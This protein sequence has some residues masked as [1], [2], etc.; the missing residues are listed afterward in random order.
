M[1]YLTI[2]NLSQSFGD[3]ILFD[4]LDMTIIPGQRVALIARNGTGKT[5]LLNV[6]MGSMLYPEWTVELNHNIRTRI[7]TQEHNLDPTKTIRD[8]LVTDDKIIQMHELGVWDYEIQAQLILTELGLWNMKDQIVW[9]LSWWEV[10][11]LSLAQV[12]IDQPDFLILDEPT[13]HLDIQMIERLESYL[14]T[15][16]ITVLLITHDRYFLEHVCT[17][18]YELEHGQIRTYT[19]NYSYYIQNKAER[20]AIEQSTFHKMKQLYKQELEW[21]RRAPQGRQTKSNYRSWQFEVVADNLQDQKGRVAHI[22]NALDLWV[23]HHSRLG[24]LVLKVKNLTKSFASKPIVDRFSHEFHA[25][26]RVGIIWP[27]GVG[28]SSLIKLLLEQIPADSGSIVWGTT[29]SVWHYEQQLPAWNPTQ[30]VLGLIQEM[31]NQ[32]RWWNTT[33]SASLLLEQFMFGQKQ[34]R[35][36]LGS[37][38]GGE[39]RRL[40]L[41]MVLIQNPNFLILDEPTND[42]DIMTINILEQFLMSYTG[43]LVIISHDRYFMDKLVDHL[44]VMEWNGKITDFWGSYTDY[45]LKAKGEKLKATTSPNEWS[46][47]QPVTRNPWHKNHYTMN[48][49]MKQITKLTNQKDKLLL[50]LDEVW[51]DYV[52]YTRIGTQINELTAKINDLEEKWFALAEQ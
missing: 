5:S 47:S 24:W 20:E 7:L 40:A 52:D 14:T 13:N 12:L 8:T 50:Q 11:R 3:K 15:G 18:I 19:G 25:G 31:G 21:I 22:N 37:L 33:M 17:H 49:Y 4:H 46:D 10:K 39:K 35:T 32:I 29:I 36:L 43:C 27:N 48:E 30:T 42:F 26:E 45:Q 1:S 6:I 16:N 2:R 34:Q 9:L 51:L 38:S 41:L 23:S 44:F 28:K